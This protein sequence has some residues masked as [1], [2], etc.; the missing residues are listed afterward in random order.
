MNFALLAN[1]HLSL[2]FI[3]SR[4]H[5]CPHSLTM[6]SRHSVG[7]YGA[8]KLMRE[9]TETGELYNYHHCTFFASIKGIFQQTTHI[10]YVCI[11]VL[12]VSPNSHLSLCTDL[13]TQY[14]WSDHITSFWPQLH[15]CKVLWLHEN[16]YGA[17]NSGG[18]CNSVPTFY[19]HTSGPVART[20]PIF[21]LY[22]PY[23]L[24]CTPVKFWDCILHG[25][26]A[27]LFFVHTHIHTHRVDTIPAMLSLLVT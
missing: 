9:V 26:D 17:V 1:I 19:P 22:L 11:N 10:Q 13:R 23:D 12:K 7:V 21:E 3:V 5:S 15:T 18:H 24:S 4:F 8:M 2:R 6:G 27:I 20:A 14:S 16:E 25:G